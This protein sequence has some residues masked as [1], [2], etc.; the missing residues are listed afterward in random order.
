MA[1]SE[2][3]NVSCYDT[4]ER[5]SQFDFANTE[6]RFGSDPS[7]F[8]QRDM[9]WE[10]SDVHLIHGEQVSS[11]KG[12][13]CLIYANALVGYRNPCESLRIFTNQYSPTNIHQPHHPVFKN[14]ESLASAAATH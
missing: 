12:R 14:L 11:T 7:H 3:L 2:P 1:G 9:S 10:G 4:L 8:T 5:R 6:C 13:G